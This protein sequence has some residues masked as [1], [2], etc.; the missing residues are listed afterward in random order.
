LTGRSSTAPPVGRDLG[1]ASALHRRSS[2]V[3]RRRVAIRPRP[4]GST[5]RTGLAGA[6]WPPPR[7]DGRQLDTAGPSP[8]RG[9]WTSLRAAR[10]RP[11]L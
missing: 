3:S 7:P 9:P 6:R 10:P 4:G 5:A 2:A 1:A 11:L 8:P